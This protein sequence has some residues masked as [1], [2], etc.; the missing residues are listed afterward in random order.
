MRASMY[1]FSYNGANGLDKTATIYPTIAWWDGHYALKQ[2]DAMFRAVGLGTSF[3][4]T[5]GCAMWAITRRIFNPISYHQGPVWPLFT[6]WGS[7]AEYRTGRPLSGYAH[8]MQNANLTW[9][10]DLGAVTELLSGDFFVPFGRSTSHQ[11]WSSA[12]VITP[13]IRGLFGFSF[14]A[15]SKAVVVDPHLP[16]TWQGATLRHVPV[17]GGSGDISFHRE[18]ATLV[19][20]LSNAPAGVGLRAKSSASVG[21]RTARSP[22]RGRGR[23]SRRSCRCPGQRPAS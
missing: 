15:E 13:A 4:P 11:M 1:A 7:V 17:A 5:G 9:E 23:H 22:R 10:Q 12:M 21:F 2:P 16:A 8:L 6:G 14:D 19:V 20:R 18:G 3:R